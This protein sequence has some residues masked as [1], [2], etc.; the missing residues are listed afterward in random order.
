MSDLME[1]SGAV[2]PAIFLDHFKRQKEWKQFQA[3]GLLMKADSLATAHSPTQLA[4]QALEVVSR[5]SV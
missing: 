4:Q 5:A 3:D 2:H 1:E